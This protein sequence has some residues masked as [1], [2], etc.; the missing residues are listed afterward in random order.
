MGDLEDINT[1]RIE[2]GAE[3]E[4]LTFTYL[5]SPD[6]WY[7]YAIALGP[8]KGS[9]AT[10]HRVSLTKVDTRDY[11]RLEESKLLTLRRGLSL[12]KR[13]VGP[14]DSFDREEL[15]AIASVL[16]EHRDSGCRVQRNDAPGLLFPLWHEANHAD[17][18]NKA[19]NTIGTSISSINEVVTDDALVAL[20]RFGTLEPTDNGKLRTVSLHLEIDE[21]SYVAQITSLTPDALAN[22]DVVCLYENKYFDRLQVSF[23]NETGKILVDE[24]PERDIVWNPEILSNIVC[25]GQIIGSNAASEMLD[26]TPHIRDSQQTRSSED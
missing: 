8:C 5:P 18:Q 11:E 24:E 7:G 4:G 22:I 3:D 6:N 10:P 15:I 9:Q 21:L 13:L 14:F 19:N 20:N 1:K 25:S 12:N 26:S 16:S 23:N 17:L 2:L